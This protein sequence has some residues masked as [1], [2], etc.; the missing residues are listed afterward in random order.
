MKYMGSKRAMLQ[1]GLGELLIRRLRLKRRFVDLF[2]GSGAVATYIAAKSK[3]RVIGW[4]LQR[5]S[6]VLTNAVITR[7]SAFDWERS[8]KS[9]YR[10]A[11]SRIGSRK[12][13]LP[14]K[15]T[16]AVVADARDCCRRKRRFP[17][18]R[19]YGGHYFSPHQAIWL[20]ALRQTVPNDQ[21]G[22]TIAVAAVIRAA[23]Q[24]AAAPGHT[25][26]PFQPTRTAKKY[27]LEAWRRD[28][29]ARTKNAFKQIAQQCAR[30]KGKAFVGDANKA[31]KK[32]QKGDLA[33][34][35][36]P[37]S[38]VHYSRFYHVLESVARGRCGNVS[39]TGRYPATKSRP[40]SRYSVSTEAKNALGELFE[41][42]SAKNVKTIVT[43]P[44][45]KCSNG[46]SGRIVR[47]LAKKYFR[48]EEQKVNSTFSS[49]GGV[50]ENG[51]GAAS[52]EARSGKK[53]LVLVLSPKN[54]VGRRQLRKRSVKRHSAKRRLSQKQ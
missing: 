33:F 35:D 42:V 15:I 54:G 11:R 26:Q 3:I 18:T 8:W 2:C 46:L 49:L 36:P 24:C 13:A 31:A 21:P 43:F 37:Y 5:Y 14:P 41:K 19:A 6:A 9:W 12:I 39:G 1:N 53:E 38:A 52:R 7:D 22:R 25:A 48:I 44:V 40:W 45:H 34:I 27:L 23:S 30:S 32:L 17:L 28:L 16:H 10:R 47:N 4:D 50:G 29:L 51:N 20:D